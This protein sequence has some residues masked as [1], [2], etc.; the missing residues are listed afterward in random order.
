MEWFKRLSQIVTAVAPIL[1]T[2]ATFFFPQIGI[3]S[4]I[5]SALPG[6]IGAAEMAYG[7]GQG[8]LKKEYV[9]DGAERLVDA[10]SDVST[11]GQ[12]ETWDSL[13]PVTGQLI[14]GIVAAVNALAPDTITTADANIERMKAGL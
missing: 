8:P 11:G 3:A 1:S 2:V 13:K 4:K 6:L 12:K 5:L 10:M 14:D 9:L 7:D